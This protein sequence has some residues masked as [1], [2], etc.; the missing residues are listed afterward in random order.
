MVMMKPNE[1]TTMNRQPNNVARS[2][3]LPMASGQ[4]Q[5]VFVQLDP[6]LKQ[7]LDAVTKYR[8][9][10]EAATNARQQQVAGNA[11]NHSS[12]SESRLLEQWVIN[13]K[14]QVKLLRDLQATIRTLGP[15][16]APSLLILADYISLPLTA[17]FHISPDVRVSA[18]SNGDHGS[19]WQSKNVSTTYLRMLHQEAA[20]CIQ[21][22]S[23]L[24]T[25]VPMRTT[26]VPS[27]SLSSKHAI[28]FLVALTRGIPSSPVA[29]A[30]NNKI[31]VATM[32]NKHT[33]ALGDGSDC[34]LAI[35]QALE[36]VLK[37]CPSS[38]ELVV[39][40]DGGL[41]ARLVDCA[42]A[43]VEGGRNNNSI[44]L[45]SND[46]V[47]LE[48]VQLLQ[49]LFDQLAKY[50]K[51]W[52][53][54]F[55]GILVGLYRCLISCQRQAS[56]GQSVALE[57][58]CLGCIQKLLRIT[59]VP[60]HNHNK[61]AQQRST[62]ADVGAASTATTAMLQNL[63]LLARN[64]NE[65]RQS[66]PSAV[67]SSSTTNEPKESSSANFLSQVQ[68]R[69]VAPL[70]IIL[71]QAMASK[72]SSVCLQAT[73]LCQVVLVETR[74]CWRGTSLP[75]VALECCLILQNTTS[76]D[77]KLPYCHDKDS[78]VARDRGSL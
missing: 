15:P 11:S 66:W 22:Y 75:E 21:M 78:I 56:T 16:F 63:Q 19:Y 17:I 72:A 29:I 24:V 76:E 7:L 34:W 67:E 12:N 37:A 53:A 23:Q 43:L 39:A 32:D 36:T 1:A 6:I 77:G 73:H 65:S 5:V 20:D 59:L 47:R 46:T 52:Q 9:L 26:P 25:P 55:P 71:R 61:Q 54:M 45:V 2:S 49:T 4:T 48:S 3:R 57:C 64:A 27:I 44:D 42:T 33:N 62:N 30:A 68:Q 14:L 40:L 69:A 74:T 8:Q 41:V 70:I 58:G 35:L 31:V 28:Q 38:E 51:V 13:V 18:A 60:I 10:T 50:P